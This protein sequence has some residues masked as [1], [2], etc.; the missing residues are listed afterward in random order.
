MAG[1]SRALIAMGAA[2]GT[3]PLRALT[4]VAL[5]DGHDAAIVA[6]SRALRLHGF[7]VIYC[8]FH[9]SPRHIVQAAVQEDADVIGISSYNGGHAEFMEDLFKHLR[10]FGR[11]IPVVCGGGGTITHD[12]V[13]ELLALGVARVFLPGETLDAMATDVKTIA[14]ERRAKRDLSY[15]TKRD[16]R[17]V[18]PRR[19]RSAE[20]SQP[21]R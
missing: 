14:V 11:N 1:V 10:A 12:D 19:L 20:S 7:E 2:T 3:A 18:R 21:D 16:G 5:C 4:A 13:H 6:V 8:G 15:A 17:R 9:K